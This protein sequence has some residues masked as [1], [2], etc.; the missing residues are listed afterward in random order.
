MATVTNKQRRVRRRAVNATSAART[1]AA[2]AAP[3]AGASAALRGRLVELYEGQSSEAVRFRYG[4]LVFDLATI[5]F[6]V[7]TSFLPRTILTE[8]LD[9]LFGLVILADVAARFFISRNKLRELANPV[10]WADAV[11]VISF[12]APLSGEAAGFLRVLRTL[13]LLHTYQLLSRVRCDSRFFRVNEDVIFAVTHLAVFIFIMTAI[14]YE[15]QHRTNSE[16]ANYV[17]ALYF[18]VSS[19]TT[20]GYGDIVLSGTLGRFISVVIMIFGVTLFFRLARAIL[21][22]YKVRFP[23]PQCGLQRHEVDAVHCKACGHLLNIPDE[24]DR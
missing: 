6:I 13:R 17:D 8:A 16:I 5:A 3:S 4:L 14:V 9:A 11:A 21:Q 22:P 2:L 18:T 20:T 24:G 1:D 19:L 23:C 7:V 10:T 12:L 15:T